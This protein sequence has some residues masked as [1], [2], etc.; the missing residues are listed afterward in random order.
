MAAEADHERIAKILDDNDLTFIIAGMGGGT[1]TGA[2][3]VIARQARQAGQLVVGVAIMPFEAEGDGKR[4]AGFD[5]MRDFKA[6]CNSL[7]ELD[8]E[9]LNKLAPDYPIKR[10]FGVMSDLVVDM[11]QELAQIVTEPSTINVDFADLKRIIEAGGTAKWMSRISSDIPIYAGTRWPQTERWMSLYRGVYP[12]AFDASDVSPGEINRAAIEELRSRGLVNDG[13]RIII[14]KGDFSGIGGG[15]N[16]M[17]IVEVGQV[18][19]EAE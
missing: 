16:A 12:I 19:G 6:A 5:G 13:D 17:K 11:V 10:A 2:A 15:T 14:T 4:A 1:G 3:P 8:N 9:N 7:I 18:V